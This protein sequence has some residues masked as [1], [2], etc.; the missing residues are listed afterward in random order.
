MLPLGSNAIELDCHHSDISRLECVLSLTGVL[1][2][3][4]VTMCWKRLLLLITLAANL[5]GMC[6]SVLFKRIISCLTDIDG[7]TYPAVSAFLSHIYVHSVFVLIAHG[8][9][10]ER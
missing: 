6:L 5:M 7:N 9:E 3:R 1:S 4:Q 2:P 8:S 10:R